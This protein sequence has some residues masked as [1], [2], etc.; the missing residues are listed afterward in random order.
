MGDELE[1]MKHLVERMANAATTMQEENTKLIAALAVRPA[2]PVAAG[3]GAPGAPDPAIARSEKMAKVSF[4]LRKSVKIKDFKE[5]QELSIR[6]WLKRFDQEIQ[7]VKKK[8][9]INDNLTRDETID[10]MKDK[11]DYAVIK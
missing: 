3:G 8:S 6:D 9:G 4:A 7:A 2:A 11:L 5:A 10:R 1:E